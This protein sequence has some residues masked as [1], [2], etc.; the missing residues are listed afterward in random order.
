MNLFVHFVCI[1]STVASSTFLG[2][3]LIDWDKQAKLPP[4]LCPI[5]EGSPQG[6]AIVLGQSLQPDG[7]PS[8]V[9]K[10]R[11]LLA[12]QL[13][14]DGK[15][16]KVI[17]SGGD[18]A[19]V[20][21]TEASELAKVLED[22]GIDS[23]AIIQEA[24]ATTTAE[25]AWFALRWLPMGTG[26]LYLVT[27]DFHMPRATYIFK[28]TLNYFYKMLED[29]YRDDPRWTSETKLYPRLNLTQV[30]AH[31]FCGTNASR[32]A[33]DNQTADVNLQSLRKRALNELTYL[34]DAEVGQAM[35]GEPLNKVMYIWP[36]QIN[37]TLDPENDANFAE[38]MAQAM[39]SAEKLCR[40]VAPPENVEPLIENPL[41]LPIPATFPAGK[42][43]DDWY[44]V[45]KECKGPAIDTLPPTVV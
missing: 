35:Y 17:V 29:Q 36:I 43:A 39:N 2:K 40:C 45:I 11:A 42:T 21:H 5:E 37:V 30:A 26:Q 8:Q 14:D 38:A 33:D 32:N 23:S 22:V 18:P 7:Q 24:Q 13:I 41:A 10:D 4:W 19:G 28:E 31:S 1:L 25:N 15:V 16:G 12:K 27:S 3:Q 9:L 6:V 20:G 44:D 34:G